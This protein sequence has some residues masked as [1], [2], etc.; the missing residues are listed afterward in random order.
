MGYGA[1]VA[2]VEEEKGTAVDGGEGEGVRE[3]E[4]RRRSLT[5]ASEA[6]VAAAAASELYCKVRHG[7]NMYRCTLLFDDDDDDDDARGAGTG[8]VVIDSHDQGLAAGQFA[9]FYDGRRGRGQEECLGCGI[10][11]EQPRPT[12]LAERDAHHRDF[13]ETTT[14][15]TT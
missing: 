12:F 7:E 9:V 5:G 1:D 6:A 8:T 15:A 13:V 10:I 11:L 14:K 2:N 3:V 4:Q